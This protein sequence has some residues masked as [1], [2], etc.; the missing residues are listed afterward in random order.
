MPTRGEPTTAQHVSQI[1]RGVPADLK[2]AIRLEVEASGTNMNDV[3]VA[4]LAK[5]FGVSFEPSG[6]RSA[7]VGESPDLVLKMPAALR[8]AIKQRALNGETSQRDLVVA[9]LCK[10]F[11]TRFAAAPRGRRPSAGQVA[12]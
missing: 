7:G 6:I 9:V 2:E 3:C 4:V 11:G 5:H 12:A 10:H 8:H 1:N